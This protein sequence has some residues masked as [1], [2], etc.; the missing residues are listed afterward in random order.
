ME[1][2]RELLKGSISLLLL[3]LL[4]RGEM[5]GYQILQTAAVRSIRAPNCSSRTRPSQKRGRRVAAAAAQPAG[6]LP[7]GWRLRFLLLRAGT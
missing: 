3:N 5:Y 2:D 7:A 1:I 6:R 4:S